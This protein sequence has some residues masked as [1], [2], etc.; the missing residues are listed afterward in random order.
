MA[1]YVGYDSSGPWTTAVIDWRWPRMTNHSNGRGMMTAVDASM[2]AST[3]TR[4][5]SA[6]VLTA[7]S[8][9]CESV[10]RA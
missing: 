10:H 8:A 4:R 7:H 2:L 1:V 3:S 6:S 5:L 9:A